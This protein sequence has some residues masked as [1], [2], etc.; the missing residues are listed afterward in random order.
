MQKLYFGIEG[1]ELQP[2]ERDIVL[3]AIEICMGVRDD[4]PGIYDPGRQRK[5]VLA[6]LTARQHVALGNG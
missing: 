5:Y 3:R 6:A 2:R 4:I 1:S